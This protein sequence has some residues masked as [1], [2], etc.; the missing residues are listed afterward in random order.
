MIIALS[1]GRLLV[2]DELDAKL[3]PKLLKFI[4]MLFKI[5]KLIRI[6]HSCY[7]LHTIFQR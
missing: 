3:H 7:L 2:F 5:L 1:E 4:I 6:M